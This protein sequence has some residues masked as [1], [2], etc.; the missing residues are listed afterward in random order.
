MSRGVGGMA[1]LLGMAH[2][3]ETRINSDSCAP[4]PLPKHAVIEKN[5]ILVLCLKIIVW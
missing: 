1:I 3:K 2:V 5:E 4:L